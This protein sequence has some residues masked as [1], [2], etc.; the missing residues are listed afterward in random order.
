M[1]S[2]SQTSSLLS[3][4]PV[5]H[6]YA[7][8]GVLHNSIAYNYVPLHTDRFISNLHY[9]NEIASN[10]AEPLLVERVIV[11]GLLDVISPK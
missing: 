8:R 10:R 7:S 11:G 5:R 6:A 3:L 2:S 9:L 4:R 1:A